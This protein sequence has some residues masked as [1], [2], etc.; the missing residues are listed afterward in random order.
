MKAKEFFNNGI[1]E[2]ITK[3]HRDIVIQLMENY[4][5]SKIEKVI[6]LAVEIGALNGYSRASANLPNAVTMAE[7]PKLIKKVLTELNKVQ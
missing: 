4:A 7:M 1:G 3:V 2:D 5:N 6:E